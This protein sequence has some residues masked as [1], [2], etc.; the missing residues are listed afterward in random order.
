MGQLL[1]V[2]H[3]RIALNESRCDPKGNHSCELKLQ[4]LSCLLVFL[5]N[6][7]T[8]EPNHPDNEKYDRDFRCPKCHLSNLRVSEKNLSR[9]VRHDI[10]AAAALAAAAEKLEK[11]NDLQKQGQLGDKNEEEELF[12]SADESNQSNLNQGEDGEYKRQIRV[13][14]DDGT[15]LRIRR[16]GSSSSNN[17][18]MVD[19]EYAKHKEQELE[20]EREPKKELSTSPSLSNNPFMNSIRN[21]IT[22]AFS[23][24]DEELSP[25]G[26]SSS[27]PPGTFSSDDNHH[28]NTNNNNTNNNNTNNSKTGKTGTIT[29]SSNT[30]PTRTG[31]VV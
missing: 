16:R 31:K 7:N 5:W 24:S 3:A 4:C 26:I 2:L 11:K 14:D 25:S 20:S 29:G 10:K 21:G 9:S 8:I 6:N 12:H 18:V 30:N 22:K 1:G 19:W 23:M 28:N 15:V 13:R 17:A 27:I